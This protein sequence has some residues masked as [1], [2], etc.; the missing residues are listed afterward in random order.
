[1]HVSH[2]I[3]L[4]WHQTYLYLTN[5]AEK[6]SI[7]LVHAHTVCTRPFLLLLK[8]PAGYEVTLV[9]DRTSLFSVYAQCSG[10]T[11]AITDGHMAVTTPWIYPVEER[12]NLLKF[13]CFS[14][15]D[16][17]AWSGSIVGQIL[18]LLA[19]LARTLGARIHALYSRGLVMLAKYWSVDRN[20]KAIVLVLTGSCLINQII[21][22]SM[23]Q[24]YSIWDAINSTHQYWC[25]KSL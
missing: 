6:C 8:G 23:M 7:N 1:M 22:F 5:Y 25:Q 4:L 19:D 16:Y 21:D 17:Q 2:V 12:V 15:W 14:W 24:C 3:P 20:F 10:I 9:Y 13:L 18:S 11:I